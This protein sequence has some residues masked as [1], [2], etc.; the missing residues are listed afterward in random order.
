MNPITLNRN[1]DDYALISY[2]CAYSLQTST[3]YI[4]HIHKTR[5]IQSDDKFS[6]HHYYILSFDHHEFS[7][8][9]ERSGLNDLIRDFES[10]CRVRGLLPLIDRHLYL[11]NTIEL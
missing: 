1:D 8:K 11:Q 4:G 10:R 2:V 3:S 9:M 6:P 7:L 5:K